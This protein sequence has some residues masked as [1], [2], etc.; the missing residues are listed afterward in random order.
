MRVIS[1]AFVVSVILCAC[2]S[3]SRQS[4]ADSIY[5]G[6]PIVTVNDAQ[7][8]AEAVAVRNGRILAVGSAIEINVYKQQKKMQLS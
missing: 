2:E 3:E 7:P 4:A 8:S 5:L 6:G 1:A